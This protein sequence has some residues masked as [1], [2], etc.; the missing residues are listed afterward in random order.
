MPASRCCTC[1]IEKALELYSEK[2]VNAICLTNHFYIDSPIFTGKTKD[3]CIDSY[4]SDYEKMKE[5]AKPYGIKI[6]LGCEIRFTENKNDYLIYGVNRDILEEAF[7]YF[8]SG[9]E[10]FRKNVVLKNSL[11]IQAHPFRDN[12]TLVDT[13]LL[14]GFE[15]L[16]LCNNHNNRIASSA[17]FAKEQG[18]KICI[19][20]SD[21]HHDKP[22]YPATI[23]MLSKTIPSDSFELVELIKSGDYIFL[24]GD[25]H[26]V[27]P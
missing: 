5:L 24:L 1:S 3:G 10:N 19:G 6:L 21:F 12:M 13:A 14:D 23:L 2:G 11:F 18:V 16:N 25:N 20:G 15:T 27:I 26:I 7:D 8:D 22:Y 4:L 17:F 9:L